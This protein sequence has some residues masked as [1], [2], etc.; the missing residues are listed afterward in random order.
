MSLP[1]GCS[2]SDAPSAAH[3]CKQS[4][5][6]SDRSVLLRPARAHGMRTYEPRQGRKAA[7]AVCF[8][9]A[10]V[11]LVLFFIFSGRDRARYSHRA[12]RSAARELST[13]VL[14]SHSTEISASTF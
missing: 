1:Q 2:G 14:P 9:S 6:P 8:A 3:D 4:L 7:T 10:V 12:A 5:P 11:T 13:H